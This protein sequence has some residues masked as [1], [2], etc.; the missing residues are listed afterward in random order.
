M[1]EQFDKVQVIKAGFDRI[2]TSA[3]LARQNMRFLL[4]CVEDLQLQVAARDRE[5][6]LLRENEVKQKD[7]NSLLQMNVM[8]L[9]NSL[10][11]SN[12]K[13]DEMV[14]KNYL[15]TKR[16]DELEKNL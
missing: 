10:N 3:V 9:T 11:Q 4:E 13:L 1:S 12:V 2:T 7:R 15:L 5:N 14:A 16:L 8:H 6:K